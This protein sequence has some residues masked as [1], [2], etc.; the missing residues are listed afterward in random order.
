MSRISTATI[1]Q[2][3]REAAE[4]VTG[5]TVTDFELKP[6]EHADYA[7]NV[8]MKLAAATKANPR[9]LAQKMAVALYQADHD[10]LMTIEVAGPGFMNITMAARH[11]IKELEQIDVHYLKSDVGQGKKVQVEF[12]S[13]NPTGPLTLGNARG[14]FLGDV[15]ANILT[16]QGYDVTR[17][18]YFNDAGTQIRKLV[19]SVQSAAGAIEVE[20]VQYKGAYIND[21]A[22]KYKKQ[23]DAHDPNLA[24]LLTQDNFETFIQDA[25]N[26][27]GVT[28]DEWFNEKSLIESGE[29]EA[30]MSLLRDRG[31]VYEKDDATWL[32]AT[33]YGDERDR[34]LIKSGGDVTYLANDIAYHLNIFTRRGFDKAIKLWGA[35]HVGQVPSLKLTIEALEPTKQLEFVIIQWVRLMKDGHE[36]KMSKRAGTFVTVQD[37]IDELDVAVGDAYGQAVARF[38]FLMRS[39]DTS[40]D[41]DMDLAREQS[42]KNPYFY[43]MYAYARAHSILVKANERGIKV[44]QTIHTLDGVETHIVKQMTKLPALIDQM[45]ADYGVHRLTFYGLEL[46]KKFQEYY[47]GTRIIDLPPEQA[48]QKLYFVSQFVVFMDQYWQLLGIKPVIRME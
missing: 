39:A 8:A 13:A 27:L 48:A 3:I 18:Y 28:F 7:T 40:M 12:I 2:M 9:E 14:G 11:W 1:H 4:T 29:F 10:H 30:A 37:L 22:V 20:E 44:A 16:S 42:A 26:R 32:K 34:V 36:V 17:E 15:I 24:E 19:E 25:I 46:A 41:F 45:A 33:D 38:M 35:D 31:L 6:S 23:I 21:L 43:V 5:E 47:E